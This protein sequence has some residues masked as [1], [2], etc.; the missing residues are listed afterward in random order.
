MADET[1]A[2]TPAEEI[3]TTDEILQVYEHLTAND[4]SWG[5]CVAGHGLDPEKIARAFRV[6]FETGGGQQKVATKAFTLGLQFGAMRLSPFE[7]Y[8]EKPCNCPVCVLARAA[9][10]A[11][12]DDPEGGGGAPS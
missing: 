8:E 12:A 7:G 11:Q 6:M 4:K 9:E 1:A 3:F 5:E 2:E 10:A